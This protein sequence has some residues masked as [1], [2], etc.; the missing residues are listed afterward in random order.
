[1]G[2]LQFSSYLW[3]TLGAL[4]TLGL[5]AFSR[6]RL[7]ILRS[8]TLI[9]L[10]I[11]LGK[12][13]FVTERVVS[14]YHLL[15]DISASF[16][17]NL[18]EI[19][20]NRLSVMKPQT[21][22]IKLYPFADKL[23]ATQEFASDFSAI[24]GRANNVNAGSTNLASAI[25]ELPA[26]A[27][28]QIFLISDGYLS[29]ENI[30]PAITAAKAKGYT[31]YPI[32]DDS[33]EQISEDVKITQIAAPL[34]ISAQTK[35]QIRTTIT[36]ST[37]RTQR[38]L[39]KV[40]HGEIELIS[41]IVTIP[42][43][44]ERVFEQ[45]SDPKQEGLKAISAQFFPE[46]DNYKDSSATAYLSTAP[47][48]KVLIISG[49][50][51]DS[52]L[53]LQALEPQGYGL[54]VENADSR[55]LPLLN[56]FSAVI[57][58]N[59]SATQL[60]YA[61]LSAIRN[62]VNNGGGLIMTGGNKS[63][64]L[65]GYIDSPIEEVL[66]VK[67]TPPQAALKR[68]NIAI[69]LVLDKS[70]SMADEDRILYAR[71]AAKAVVSG[72]K[73]EDYLGVIGFDSNPF[74]VQRLDLL[75]NIRNNVADRI[76]RLFP[77]RRTNLL[78]AIDEARRGLEQVRAGRK[79]ILVL[80]DGRIPDGGP[81][82][83]EIVKSMRI[84]GITVSTVM[85]GEE[86]DDALLR[87]M[88]EY[89]GGTFYQTADPRSLPRIFM[90]DV[91]VSGGEKTLKEQS[92]Y[93][94]RRGP[95]SLD[96]TQL[97]SFPSLKG[98][99]QTKPRDDANLELVV[100]GTEGAEPLLASKRYG[101]GKCLAFTSDVNGRWSQDWVGWSSF[102]TLWGE[103][104]DSVQH[105]AK[106]SQGLVFDLAHTLEQDKIA[107]EATIYSPDAPGALSAEVVLPTDLG[108]KT[109]GGGMLSSEQI[110]FTE[111]V[112][113][114]YKAHIPQLKSG[115]YQLK[116]KSGDLQSPPV[117]FQ[118]S[119][120]SLGETKGKGINKGALKALANATGGVV[121]P[122]KEQIPT[123][124]IKIPLRKDLRPY[125][126]ILALIAFT[127][128]IILREYRWRPMGKKERFNPKLSRLHG[129]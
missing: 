38:G 16:E 110:S 47:R 94:V 11:I 53:L 98:Y 55:Q 56:D 22:E 9:I 48:E 35:T 81:L 51:S 57:L 44:G 13:E 5:L 52:K 40:L 28:S 122:T 1:M 59:A 119:P 31:I 89:G 45:E 71:E 7:T 24:S 67:L 80:T 3:P 114:R 124:E 106:S 104:V 46:A 77:A 39:L 37:A 65:G 96:S 15:V 92:E 75:A 91:K 88:A 82:Y 58:A 6:S 30:E 105:K 18:A 42:P 116:L 27:G 23:G 17:P 78:P 20:L 34:V 50:P 108:S 112:P 115:R 101:K 12:P 90:Q 36:N 121:N 95:G 61:N 2:V 97:K 73:D 93:F 102:A 129:S 63:F 69:Q 76:D 85:L 99:V 72:L 4:I 43:K 109:Q 10:S 14:A 86:V 74:I 83:L 25:Q 79:H 60:G 66:P 26:S 29:G 113:G 84:L 49:E 100:A 33:Q 64:G 87:Q 117:A 32:F 19:A 8:I 111:I 68:L 128:E 118:I 21:S 62:Y 127:L 41:E 103:L 123:T 70:K 107:L 126:F 125:L 120:E 54:E